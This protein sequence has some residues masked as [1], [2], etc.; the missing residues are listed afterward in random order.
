M[1][2]KIRLAI[3]TNGGMGNLFIQANFIYCLHEYLQAEPLSWTVFGHASETLNRAVFRH[4]DFLTDWYGYGER[5]Q[6][7][8][9]DVCINLNF[10]PEV[11]TA[12]AA[13]K[14]KCPRLAG[15]LAGWED[16]LQD[17]SRRYSC[18]H[19]EADFNV[20]LLALLQGKNCLNVAD[21]TGE[22]KIPKAEYRLP[23]TAESED[24]LIKSELA[25]GEYI[26]VH[27][28]ASALLAREASLKLWPKEY[29]GELVRLLKQCFP[30]KQIVQLG[31][32]DSAESLPGV[33]V[34]LLGKTGWEDLKQLLQ[35]SWLHIDTEGGLVHLRKAL[36]GG[37][38]VVLFGPT[39]KDFY[40]YEGN[41]NI[42][43]ET[44]PHWCARLTDN[45]TVRCAREDGKQICMTGIIPA[46]VLKKIMEWNCLEMVQQDRLGKMWGSFQEER[47]LDNL[48]AR[49]RRDFLWQHDIYYAELRQ[50]SVQSL[51]AI[52]MTGHGFEW[53]PIGETPA[54]RFLTGDREAYVS[55]LSLLREKY[56][57]KIH[58]EERFA[59]L[60][61]S[62]EER[63]YDSESCPVAVDFE[64]RI[65]DGQH[66]AAWLLSKD[67]KVKLE[68]LVL[69]SF[70]DTEGMF[71][72]CKVQR[73][74]R[75]VIYGMGKLG[76]A[77]VS[78]LLSTN[79][80]EIAFKVDRSSDESLG[81]YPPEYIRE[82]IDA[83]DVVVIATANKRYLAE[84][85]DFL[86]GIGIAS[87]RIVS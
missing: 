27:R 69:H 2:D 80:A 53:W 71:P 61:R 43:A 85:T 47:L 31:E 72:F 56:D 48:D 11:M 41:I 21:V 76:Q 15:L 23:M 57:D 3:M 84:I 35:H 10:Y 16:L 79:F 38:S 78:Q 77:Y 39:P 25:P 64:G 67:S 63:G 55:Y 4:L 19:P 45:W 74:S 24:F 83:F 42:S 86:Q 1:S 40:G 44:C 66:R 26:T 50:M 37:P 29:Y 7:L 58:T 70:Y 8:S 59:R 18:S 75:V 13:A 68:V 30:E 33:D 20:Y 36:R 14:A 60:V 5:G 32:R 34:S 52:V 81:I 9:Y 87:E 46:K 65:L 73:G 6:A 51:R 82:H 17:E 22:L 62:L 49:Y 54:Y 28:G 12:S